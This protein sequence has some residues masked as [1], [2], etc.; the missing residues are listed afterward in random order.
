LFVLGSGALA[1]D[2]TAGWFWLPLLLAPFAHMYAQ[3]KGTYAL[4]RGSAL[5]RTAALSFAAV[6]TLGL[7]AAMMIALGVLD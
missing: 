4:S 2:I 1:L 5:W 7:Y 6:I 3:L